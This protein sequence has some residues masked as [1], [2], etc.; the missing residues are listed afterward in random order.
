MTNKIWY[1]S[2]LRGKLRK[3]KEKNK[4]KNAKEEKYEV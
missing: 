2:D 1:K 4:G 3:I